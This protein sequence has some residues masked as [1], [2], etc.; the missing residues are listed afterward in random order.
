MATESDLS[1]TISDTAKGPSSVTID[2]NTT[3]AQKIT[4]QIEAD[5]Y[6]ASKNAMKSGR[7]VRFAKLV[8]HGAQ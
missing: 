7:G 8:P 2:G 1:E 4:D 6:L 3:V 5:R